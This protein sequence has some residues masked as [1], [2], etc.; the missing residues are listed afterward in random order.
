VLRG[1]VATRQVHTISLGHAPHFYVAGTLPEFAAPPTTYAS[2]SI[3]ASAYFLHSQEDELPE[4][5]VEMQRSP[6]APAPAVAHQPAEPHVPRTAVARKPAVSGKSATSRPHFSRP[7][8]HSRDR[9]PAQSS[10]S[11]RPARRVGAESRPTNSHTA[12]GA[13]SASNGGHGR[14]A[15][16]PSA[17][18]TRSVKPSTPAWS[19]HKVHSNGAKTT[20]ISGATS[21]S[22]SAA[23]KDSRPSARPTHPSSSR[24]PALA[25]SAKAGSSKRFGFAARPKQETKKR[26]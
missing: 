20:G 13:R 9:K 17:S 7:A 24:K 5:A 6:A 2:A 11:S 3:P 14:P 15:A 25:T 26:G 18:G 4:P 23:R 16:R 19:Q 21:R 12:S 22:G 8:A 1:L 10:S